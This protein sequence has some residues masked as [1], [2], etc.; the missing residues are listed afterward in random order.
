MP[1][2]I[3]ENYSAPPP[4]CAALQ[5]VH[6]VNNYVKAK[7]IQDHLV[8]SGQVLDMPCG[9][10]GDLHKYRQNKPS[11]YLG[12][13]L[14]QANVDEAKRRHENTRCMFGAHFMQA[15]FTKPLDLTSHY[16][17]V[18]CQF[19][20]HYAWDAES[21]ARQVLANVAAR[22]K[23]DGVFVA[24]FPDYT[25]ILDRLVAMTQN[26]DK[27]NYAAKNGS[28]YTYRIG[29][30]HYYLEF[31]SHLSFTAFFASLREQPYGHRYTYY[32]AGAVDRV[33][34]YL[35]P[36]RELA[37]I[38]GLEGL[39]ITS[40]EGFRAIVERPDQRLLKQMR[41]STDLSEEG[42]GLVGLYRAMVLRAAKR[43][44]E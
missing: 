14:V 37:R 21:R 10:G 41:C 3:E 29:G 11:F 5:S 4:K 42:R 27:H 33:E 19:A 1:K 20:L 13:D 28:T 34:E 23:P 43:R 32:Q 24:T 30:Q 36:P 12:L 18:S 16:D 2:T 35:V 8:P 9:K 44:R 38:A 31:T 6:R 15:D 40:S 22:L 25:E 26:Q 7:L 17:L 39:K